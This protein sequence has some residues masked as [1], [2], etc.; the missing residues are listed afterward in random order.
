MEHLSLFNSYAGGKYSVKDIDNPEKAAERAQL[1]EDN[2][3]RALIITLQAMAG[4]APDDF[5]RFLHDCMTRKDSPW[6]T[7]MARVGRPADLV[8]DLQSLE[9]G[10]PLRR[11]K[12]HGIPTFVLGIEPEGAKHTDERKSQ[13]G[14]RPDGWIGAPDQ[15]T[16]IIESKVHGTINE[17]QIQRFWKELTQVQEHE[18]TSRTHTTNWASV[19]RWL[20]EYQ[21]NGL[22]RVDNA[23]AQGALRLLV[24][25]LRAYL[26]IWN[27]GPFRGVRKRHLSLA[28]RL[29]Y[30][31]HAT[32]KR[33]EVDDADLRAKAEARDHL[34]KLL[35][36]LFQAL[37][38][39]DAEAWTSPQQDKDCRHTALSVR[40]TIGKAKNRATLNFGITVEG[41]LQIETTGYFFSKD[42]VRRLLESC[43]DGSY[44]APP[45][46]FSL[47]ALL[48]HSAES[49]DKTTWRPVRTTPRRIQHQVSSLREALT[50]L[51]ETDALTRNGG[52]DGARP[53]GDT[54]ANFGTS[55]ALSATQTWSPEVTPATDPDL[56]YRQNAVQ[57]N[58]IEAWM[59][60]LLQQAK[61]L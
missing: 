38:L 18:W 20:Q 3:T 7:E 58:R 11:N 25:E 19:Y 28:R 44:A 45:E 37:E 40:K 46:G 36:D 9:P 17:Q 41:G 61:L 24:S 53:V 39:P 27:L 49:A 50:W 48:M 34:K 10:S 23:E 54:R 16:L 15:F 21:E 30:L 22:R 8:F 6:N 52:L 59:L 13:G 2:L 42:F 47:Q 5:W 26:E 56:I 14:A 1:L 51:E 4:A 60:M 31:D 32:G 29:A 12:R 35:A 57:L 33:A 55:W 43:R